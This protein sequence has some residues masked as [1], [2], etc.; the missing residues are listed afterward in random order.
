MDFGTPSAFWFSR[1]TDWPV[2]QKRC[3]RSFAAT[4][5]CSI[6][7]RTSN[8][9]KREL[10][11]RMFNELLS[12]ENGF[13]VSSELILIATILVIAL[14]V[15]LQTVRDAVLQELGDVGAAI[16]AISQDY[17]YSG[18]T[19]HASTINGSQYTDETDFCEV[20]T[21]NSKNCIGVGI[22]LVATE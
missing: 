21:A 22:A 3:A 10:I 12:D 8:K 11:M 9:E 5:L 17:S 15:G 1:A 6:L 20:S 4:V 16:G 2:M 7:N 19:G 14:V 18:A 13:I